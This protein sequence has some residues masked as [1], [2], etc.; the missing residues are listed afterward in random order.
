MPAVSQEAQAQKPQAQAPALNK[1]V[2]LELP[3]E[4]TVNFDEGFVPILAQCKGEVKWLVVSQ[5]NVK[6]ITMPGNSIIISVPPQ[7]GAISVFA[8]GIVDGKLTDFARTSI[9]VRGG[10]AP[11]GPAPG[12]G[13][14]PGPG[15]APGPNPPQGGP[16]H[17]TFIVDLNNTTPELA[18]VLNSQ[19]IQ[20]AVKNKGNFLRLYDI[21][22]PVVAQKKLDQ[23]VQ[24]VGGSAVVVIQNNAGAVLQAVAIP[25]TEQEVLG[26]INQFAGGQ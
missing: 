9:T 21:R 17:I 3:P 20:Q 10:L 22:S 2:G 13:P 8:V 6:Y 25:R 16:F 24:R 26:I 12:P 18:Q 1:V 5:V 14:N 15:P 7:G 11:P 4:Q 19:A 23:V